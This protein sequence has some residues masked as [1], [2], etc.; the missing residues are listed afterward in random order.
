ML[1][2]V[3]LVRAVSRSRSNGFKRMQIV[4]RVTFACVLEP[5]P[6]T[7]FARETTM[8][9]D[10]VAQAGAP[11]AGGRDGAFPMVSAPLWVSADGLSPSKGVC[12]RQCQG[13]S[14]EHQGWQGV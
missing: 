13:C 6:E 5:E 11:V 12:V 8:D 3:A 9:N 14:R 1:R 10:G 4:T 7:M 2:S